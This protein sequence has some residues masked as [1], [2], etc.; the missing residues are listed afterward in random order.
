MYIPGLIPLAEAVQIDPLSCNYK[1]K[2]KQYA[3]IG[4]ITRHAHHVASTPELGTN[5][6]DFQHRHGTKWGESDE[7]V[8]FNGL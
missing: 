4:F 1:R 5:L 7:N 6:I 8:F 2:A 3:V